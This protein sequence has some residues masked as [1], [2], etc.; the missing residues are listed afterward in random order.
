MITLL[1][2]RYVIADVECMFVYH[3]VR[4]LMMIIISAEFCK[5]SPQAEFESMEREKELKY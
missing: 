4:G 1:L 3:I 2:A 5:N